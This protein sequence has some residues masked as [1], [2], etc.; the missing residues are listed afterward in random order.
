M[1]YRFGRLPGD[2]PPDGW[3]TVPPDLAIQVVAPN[4]P[5]RP[6]RRQG[7]GVPRCWRPP[8]LGTLPGTRTIHVYGSD[9]SSGR[10][11]SDGTLTGGDVLPGLAI[12]VRDLFALPHA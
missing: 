7:A 11:E 1:F 6:R 9:G 12:P 5:A 2:I 8:R 10:L 3:I 4:E